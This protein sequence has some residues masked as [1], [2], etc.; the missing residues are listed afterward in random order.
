MNKALPSSHSG[1]VQKMAMFSTI[2][3]ALSNPDSILDQARD[4]T[5]QGGNITHKLRMLH[6]THMTN[7]AVYWL[8][9]QFLGLKCQ[10]SNPSSAT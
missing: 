8:K 1:S 4:C 3:G 2:T 9:V 6:S 7:G 5:R 10:G